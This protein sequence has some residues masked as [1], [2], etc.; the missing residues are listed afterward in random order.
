MET[1][2]SRWL[3][4]ASVLCPGID[5]ARLEA[6]GVGLRARWLEPHRSYHDVVHLAEVLAALDELGEAGELTDRQHRLAGLVA[7]F[8]DAIYDVHAGPGET[9]E[10]SA[11]LAREHLTDLG[12]PA[13]EVETVARLVRE[14][15]THEMRRPDAVAAGFHDADL[16]IL[17]APGHRFEAYCAQVRLEYGHVRAADF[18]RGRLA[19]LTPF[20][21]RERLYLTAHAHEHWTSRARANLARE[22]ARLSPAAGPG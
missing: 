1:L 17:A 16:W 3:A 13:S 4:D 2:R 7:W 6:V 22:I 21:R 11:L 15:A 5:V 8:H 9:E 12:L 10:A 14:S 20:V 18:A 19:V